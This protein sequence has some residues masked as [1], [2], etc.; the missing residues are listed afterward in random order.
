MASSSAK[1]VSRL[2]SIA[3][4]F[5]SKTSPL[6]NASPLKSVHKP[7]I[8]KRLISRLPVELSSSL[9]TMMPL[10]NAI[11]SARLQSSLSAESQRWGLVPQDPLSFI[12]ECRA[13][14]SG[15]IDLKNQ[16]EVLF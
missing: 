11:A 8:N 14:D 4:K 9:D 12:S 6:C 3:L 13:S 7:A 15:S 2:S 16:A 5:S 1:F 10:H